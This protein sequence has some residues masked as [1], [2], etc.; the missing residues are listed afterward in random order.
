MVYR[1]NENMDYIQTDETSLAVFDPE[2]SNTH[3]FDQIGINILN[4]LSIPCDLE[5]LLS[6][7]CEIY[8]VTCDDIKDDVEEFVTNTV[9]KKV[10]WGFM[11]VKTVYVEITDICNLNCK[12]CYNRSGMKKEPKEISKIQLEEIIKLF[13]PFGLSRVLIS[14]G[15]NVTYR[16]WRNSWFNW[17][18]FE[19]IL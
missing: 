15:T 4:F 13:F 10:V 12:T 11:N 2:I 9:E 14:G 7:L 17:W 1:K 19:F 3:F 8:D 16:V 5:L 18:I 6:K